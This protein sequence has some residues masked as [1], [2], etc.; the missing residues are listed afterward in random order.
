M[1]LIFAAAAG[2]TWAAG[3][4][5]SKT[6]DALDVR[7]GL[8]EALGGLILL[9]VTGSLPEIA[10]TASAALAGH[11]DLAVGNLIGGVAI[12]TLVLVVLD[13]ASGRSRPLCFLVG[14]LVPV[15]EALI[16]VVVLATELSGAA[17]SAS[18]NVGGISPASIAVIVL[19][20]SG[21][22]IVNR[23]R[24]KPAWDVVA[25]GSTPGRRH[26]REAHPSG[27]H[28]FAGSSTA[29]VMLL[30]GAGAVATL[31][32][33]VTLENTGSLIAGRIGVQGAIFGATFLAAASALPEIS[34]G[35]AAVKLGDLQLAVGDILGG[36][37]FQICLFVL[38]DAL[39]GT[40]V[41][42]AAHKSD[43]WLGGMGLLMTAIAASGII[44]RPKRTHF[45]LGIDSIALVVVYAFAVIG[46]TRITG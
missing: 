3:G 32:A 42:V 19:W 27:A 21:V 18:T 24:L 16:V 5:L 37:S 25:P 4:V 35:I 44:A 26:V 20:V 22:W 11:L 29:R 40:P 36:N 31:I 41:I 17:L 23:V 30:F 43:V 2:V 14:S 34:S 6:T 39:A 9:A 7:F 12:Q 28:P 8:G 10:I 1:C 15:L 13:F 38:A 46:L 45:W 33:G